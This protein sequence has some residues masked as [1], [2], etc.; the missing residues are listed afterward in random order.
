MATCFFPETKDGSVARK[1]MRDMA[2]DKIGLVIDEFWS[3]DY[4]HEPPVGSPASFAFYPGRG[5][6]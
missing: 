5:K 2:K 6:Y 1:A 4:M 3:F